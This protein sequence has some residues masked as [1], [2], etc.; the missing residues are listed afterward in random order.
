MVGLS[1][2]KEEVLNILTSVSSPVDKTGRANT[3]ELILSIAKL[4]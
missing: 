1:T 3:P 2:T 4:S